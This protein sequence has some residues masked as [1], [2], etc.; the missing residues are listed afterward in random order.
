MKS[1]RVLVGALVLIGACKDHE[2]HPPDKQERVSAAEQE[3]RA[4]A[5]DTIR[6]ES[7]QSRLTQGNAVYAE[8]CRKCHGQ[9]GEGG[10][11][12]ARQQNL[13]PPSLVTPDWPYATHI[14]S[15][16]HRIYVGHESGMPTF[17]IAGLTA[18]EIDAVAFYV[19]EQLRP[20]ALR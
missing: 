3:Y 1:W 13:N 10:T 4:A 15:V 8:K 17:G 12:Y 2:F 5:F 14:D 20:D 6:W 19:L 7:E 9:L 11:E 18:R 16:R